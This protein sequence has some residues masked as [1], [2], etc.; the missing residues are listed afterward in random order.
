MPKLARFRAKHEPRKVTPSAASPLGNDAQLPESPSASHPSS[1]LTPI[2]HVDMDAFFVSVELLA[3]PELRGKAVIVGG[4]PDQRGVVTAASY[5]ARNY[6]V[7]SA[8][9][10]RTAGRLCPHAIFLDSNHARY[11]QWSDRIAAILARYSP[12][13]EMV[14]IDEAYLDLAGTERLHGSPL[15][16]ANQLLRDVTATTNLPCSAGLAATRL[17]AKVASDQ[18]KPRGLLWVPPGS[19]SAFLAPLGVR[20]IPGIGKVT[21]NAL[22]AL[23]IRTTGQL[24]EVPE[25]KL[26]ELFGRWGTALHRKARGEDSY[27]FLV[28]AEPKSIS[29]NHT[30]GEDTCDRNALDTTLSHLTQKACKRL[31]EAGLET[32]T[33]TL[34][35]RY[36]G[37]ETHTRSK[38]LAQPANLDGTIQAVFR[39]LFRAHWN[40][41]RQVRL[42]G[43]SLGGL[44]HGPR[45]LALLDGEQ[46]EKLERLTRTADRL[47]DRFG[48]SKIQFGGSLRRDET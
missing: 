33:L 29:Q 24:A 17:V 9:P 25:E 19:E 3:R 26:E 20:K 10:L 6:G 8:M 46:R 40:A 27:E 39:D 34:T 47:R 36:A 7:H 18:A 5:E 41:R 4:R 2:L 32:R 44:M 22:Q 11:S 21:E 48:F 15:A 35:I 14:S 30:F 31:R 45:Q 37:F 42:L 1:S 12:I 28:D 23:G 38:T 16:A 13:V 43:V